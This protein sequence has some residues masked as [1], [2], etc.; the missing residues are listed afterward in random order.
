MARMVGGPPTVA[1]SPAA[2]GGPMIVATTYP[3]ESTALTRSQR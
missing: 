3:F 2:S 1:T